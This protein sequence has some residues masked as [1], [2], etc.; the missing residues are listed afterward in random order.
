MLSL[1]ATVIM[2]TDLEGSTP[3]FRALS[4]SDLSA[5]LARHQQL[6]TDVAARHQGE[7][8]MPEG[9]AFWLVFPSVTAACQAG[10]EMQDELRLSQ[11]GRASSDGFQRTKSIG[12]RL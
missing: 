10:L 12:S 2:K 4:E 8:V 9:D 5:V 6:V 3:R 1:R 11:P 7:V